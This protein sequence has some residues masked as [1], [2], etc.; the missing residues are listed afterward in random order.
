[1]SCCGRFMTSGMGDNDG[2]HGPRMTRIVANK[3][4]KKENSYKANILSA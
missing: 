3:K 1:M 4:G 2:V